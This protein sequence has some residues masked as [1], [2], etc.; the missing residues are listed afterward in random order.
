[1]CKTTSLFVRVSNSKPS[2]LNL[3]THEK[4]YRNIISLDFICSLHPKS[5]FY[6][7]FILFCDESSN[8]SHKE[9][10]LISV[11]I[12]DIDH[13][14]TLSPSESPYTPP[15]VLNFNHPPNIY[16]EELKNYF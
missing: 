8:D 6:F 14:C 9:V 12:L 4:W 1:M 15:F 2:C 5:I 11:L 16:K 10:L 7:E 13:F 3:L